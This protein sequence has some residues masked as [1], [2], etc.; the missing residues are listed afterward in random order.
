MK[1]VKKKRLRL[2]IRREKKVFELWVGVAGMECRGTL[3]DSP[4]QMNHPTKHELCSTSSRLFFFSETVEPPF[5]WQRQPFP[6]V[7]AQIHREIIEWWQ[8]YELGIWTS[9]STLN[10]A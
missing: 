4:S 7:A 5:T 1:I 3:A 9:I 6:Q 10:T 8:S 2:E